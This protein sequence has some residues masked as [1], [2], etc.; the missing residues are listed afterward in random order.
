MEP[1]VELGWLAWLQASQ[2]SAAV[3]ASSG[4]YPAINTLH[5][6]GI[7]FIV[8][9]LAALD[10]RFLGFGKDIPAPAAE[11][12]LRRIAAAGLL[13]AVPSGVLLFMTEAE[14]LPANR[15][16][17]VKMGLF[18][19]AILNA[20]LFVWLWRQRISQWDIR[21]PILGQAQAAASLALWIGV[22]SSG[23]LIAYY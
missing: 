13:V 18:A 11:R 15:L 7:A 1:Q 17:L 3:K 21:P 12:F 14:T 10:L 20:A 19:A 8:G 4:L 23:R 22:A 2:L 6:L 9:S 5:V 16:F